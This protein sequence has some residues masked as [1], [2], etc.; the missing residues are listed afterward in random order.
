MI[1]NCTN[2]ASRR[3]LIMK[4]TKE[5]GIELRS[6]E[7]QEVLGDVPGWI[8]RNGIL[9]LF[10][11]VFVLLVGSWFF[12][13][14]D[15]IPASVTLTSVNPPVHII[16]RATG[17]TD[18][19]YV[20]DKQV[21]KAGDYLAVIENPA[22]TE[23]VLYIRSYL[24]KLKANLDHPELPLLSDPHLGMLQGSYSTLIRSIQ[25]IIRF[26]ALNFYPQK[27]S[28]IAKQQSFHVQSEKTISRQIALTKE[29][30][31]LA[32]NSYRRDSIIHS[33]GVIT[34]DNMDKATSGYLAKEQELENAY[35]S[36]DQLR[37]QQEEIKETLLETEKQYREAESKLQTEMSHA[38]LQL[39][40]ELSGWEQTYVLQTPVDGVVTFTSYW[41]KNQNILSGDVVF[42]IIPAAKSEWIGKAMLPTA[43]SG[44]VKVGQ[45]VHIRL[46]NFP[47]EEFGIV[48]G[49]VKSV[50]LVPV[51]G[52]YVL[53]ISLPNGLTTNY[54]KVLPFSQEMS[55]EAQ[56]IT[57]DLRLLE[58]IFS[59][60]KKL[61]I[62]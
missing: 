29:Q 15:T 31:R 4:D 18:S 3:E 19:L 16:A 26:R 39:E 51:A 57:E 52:N 23:D 42:T 7:A 55:G 35:A 46:A 36:L 27:L 50:S 32:G 8:L 13:Y 49:E 24:K 21:L 22:T 11:V 5:K 37:M 58:R 41:S 20:Q 60:I 56:I 9:W 44:K 40:N 1:N 53:E 10:V 59:P 6:E 17:K 54:G 47:Y 30:Y 14:P 2:E 25:E 62:Q 34:L 12:K 45:Q 33:K 48:R 28:A 61:L 38:L 43:R